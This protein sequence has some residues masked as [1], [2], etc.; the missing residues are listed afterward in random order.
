MKRKTKNQTVVENQ[1]KGKNKELLTFKEWIEVSRH[2]P[3]IRNYKDTVFRMIYCDKKE[4]LVLYNA[5]NGT[6]YTNEEDLQITTLENAVYMNMKN[7][8]SFVLDLRLN[9]YEHQATVNP[10]MPL[11]D[12]MYVARV[13]EGL[14]IRKDLYSRKQVKL[15]S[16]RFITFYNGV[17]EQPERKECRLS[18][19]FCVKDDMP[20]LELIVTQLNI[21]PG[22]NEDLMAKCP[23]LR[24][25]MLY[26]NRIRTYEK[27]MDLSEAVEKAVNECI[28]EGI[29]ADFLK[30]NKAEV[31]SMSI[32][33]YDEELHNRTLY[34]DGFEDGIDKGRE[35]GADLKLIALISRKLQKGKTPEVIADELEEDIET[36]KKICETVKQFAPEYDCERIYE[37][38]H[39]SVM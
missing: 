2:H 6:Y 30:K 16:P 5:V 13:F 34:E 36:V 24:Q 29:L 26:V 1:P 23:T 18:D 21:N 3:P 33:E 20:S 8:V 32:F 17:E 10:N 9:L 7:D 4:L 28:S 22:Y 37:A 25:Y 12:L 39:T 35:E 27:T 11:R 38:M 14:V 31:V 15:P 19:A